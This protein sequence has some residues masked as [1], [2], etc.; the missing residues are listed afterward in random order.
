MNYTAED[1]DLLGEK[2]WNM[3]RLYNL[4]AGIDPSQ[5]ALPE[6]CFQVPLDFPEG[7]K[8]FTREDFSYLINDYYTIRGWDVNG[9]R[10]PEKLEALGLRSQ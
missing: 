6:I 3:E 8:P 7:Y 2:I 9:Y 5:D 10:T 1:F 4:N